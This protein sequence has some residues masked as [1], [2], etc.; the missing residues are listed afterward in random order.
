[1]GILGFV[2]LSGGAESTGFAAA[3]ELGGGIGFSFPV[4][5]QG[6]R[7]FMNET[8]IQTLSRILTRV[9]NDGHVIINPGGRA[10][11]DEIVFRSF[12][13]EVQAAASSASATVTWP[14]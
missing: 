13:S 8:Q 1:M 5:P 2:P 11:N 4:P 12:V 9:L 6:K 3:R 14:A 7:N 10:A